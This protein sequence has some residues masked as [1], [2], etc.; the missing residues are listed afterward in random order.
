[1]VDEGGVMT[2]WSIK[3]WISCLKWKHLSIVW[4]PPWWYFQS[5]L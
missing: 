1:M 2:C 5:E 3:S 4:P